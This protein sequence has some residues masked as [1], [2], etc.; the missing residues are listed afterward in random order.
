MDKREAIL[1]RLVEIA[2]A[3]EGVETALRNVESVSD[4]KLPAI[5]VLDADEE[6]DD[7]DPR[8]RPVT[9]PRRV[10]MTPEV[11][12]DLQAAPETVGTSLNSLRAAFVKA[13]LEDEEIRGLTLN[14]IGVRYDGCTTALA[15]GRSMTG[16]M[17][18]SLTFTYTL[19]PSDL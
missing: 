14:N 18:V 17:G 5:T 9:A 7:D 8:G 6:A 1:A 16:A 13:V 12:I 15:R 3:V 2:T 4:H 11:Y 10:T 19:L